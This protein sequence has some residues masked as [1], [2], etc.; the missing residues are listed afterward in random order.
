MRITEKAQGIGLRSEHQKTLS[1]RKVEGIDFL[2]LAPENWMG[3]GGFK[4]D[5]LDKVASIYPI[6]AHSLNLSIAGFRPLNKEFLNKVKD[7]LDHYNISIYSDH[8]CFTDDQKGYLYDLL[9]APR[10][11]EVI[12][13]ICDR[14]GQVQDIIKRPLALENI[15]YYYQYDNDMDELE[16]I[17]TIL[18]KSGAKLLLDINNVYVNGQNHNY[19]PYEFIANIK[20][21][22]ISYYHIAGHYKSDDFIIDTHGR[23]VIQEVKDL[24]K[25]TI[26]KHGWHPLLLERDNFVP[27]LGDLVA[28]LNNIT[29]FIGN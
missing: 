2:E 3:L 15:S 28:E 29:S 16:F 22:S 6:I 5:Y 27:E 14:I 11:K 20:K 19:D 25:F 10:E 4:R 17:N 23:D 1:A 8:L 24:A 26:K 12:T 13:Y 7:F 18:E 21:G 9:P